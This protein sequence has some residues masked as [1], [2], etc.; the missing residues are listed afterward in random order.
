MIRD[1]KK[2]TRHLKGVTS[3]IHCKNLYNFVKDS[4]SIMNIIELG[5]AH[6]KSA[7]Y[8]A[9]ALKEKGGGDVTTIDMKYSIERTPNIY[10]LMHELHLRN[11]TP[12]FSDVCYT[13]ELLKLIEKQTINDVCIPCFDFCYIDGGHSWI[14]GYGFLLVEKLLKPGSWILFDDLYIA[15][16]TDSFMKNSEYV[17][18]LSEEEKETQQVFKIFKLLVKQHPNIDKIKIERVGTSDSV[19]GWAR[20]KI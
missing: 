3:E 15:F 18:G 19:W 16:S 8:M 13:W 7:C 6:G 11:I 5:T 12:I 4:E 14:D 10:V 2:L 9:T 17:K 1:V 20:K